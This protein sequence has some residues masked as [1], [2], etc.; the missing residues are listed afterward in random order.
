[1]NENFPLIANDDWKMCGLGPEFTKIIYLWIIK[2]DVA[3]KEIS[4]Y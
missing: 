2:K 4:E 3:M 1:M